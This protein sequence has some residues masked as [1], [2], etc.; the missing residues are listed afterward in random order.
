MARSYRTFGGDFLQD[1]RFAF[2]LS[3]Q[4]AVISANR[5][6]DLPEAPTCHLVVLGVGFLH[7]NFIHIFLLLL[8]STTNPSLRRTMADIA[9]NSNSANIGA[10]AD[11]AKPTTQAVK[12]I[13]QS[14]I[15]LLEEKVA[16][17]EAELKSY[18]EA[19]KHNLG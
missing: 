14:Y 15:E 1:L 8:Y 6:G 3:V 13:E 17:L 7:W 11:E 12:G 5:P 9:A 2:Y 19:R 4:N 18:K 10:S 16:L